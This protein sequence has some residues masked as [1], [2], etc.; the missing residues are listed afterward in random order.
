MELFAKLLGYALGLLPVIVTGIQTVAGDK[1]AGATKSQMATDALEVAL[2]GAA[3]V[4]PAGSTNAALAAGAGAAAEETIDATS[5][6]ASVL[7]HIKATNGIKSAV[8]LTKATGAYQAATAAAT[9]AQAP[10]L[11]AAAAPAGEEVGEAAPAAV[12]D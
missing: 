1:V 5:A 10:L 3:N 7:S 8:T 4:I 11:A 2:Q 9:T 6:I 12:A